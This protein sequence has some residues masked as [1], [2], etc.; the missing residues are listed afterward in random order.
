MQ[1]HRGMLSPDDAD[2][3]DAG[4]VTN[5][6]QLR[7]NLSVLADRLGETFDI[8]ALVADEHLRIGPYF[9]M[10]QNSSEETISASIE[11]VLADPDRSMATSVVVSWFEH[12]A[13]TNDSN[14][15]GH[16]TKFVSTH[17]EADEFL[18]RR[19]QETQFLKR[20]EE[21][22]AD[23]IADLAI[24]PAWVQSRLARMC[25][26]P[27]VLEQLAVNASFKKTRAQANHRL[28]AIQRAKR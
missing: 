15:F 8:D 21:G 26:L 16:W 28:A 9:R 12:L 10:L 24:G 5:A 6:K 14:G 17:I 27:E 7:T 25:E 23:S 20:C 3:S 22:D 2:N 4:L 11:L 13:A 1:L 19:A 18:A